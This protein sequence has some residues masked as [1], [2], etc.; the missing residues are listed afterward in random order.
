MKEKEF[1]MED[2]DLVLIGHDTI[3]G[4]GSYLQTGVII[5]NG[6]IIGQNCKIGKNVTIGNHCH[7]PDNSLIEE[8]AVIGNG[9]KFEGTLHIGVHQQVLPGTH[10]SHTFILK[11]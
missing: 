6:T 3:I 8:S 9:C 5:G 10:C 1:K 2:Q 7:I 11:P 4:K